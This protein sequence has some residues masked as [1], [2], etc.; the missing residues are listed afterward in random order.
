MQ[1]DAEAH[2]DS[3]RKRTKLDEARG[4][5]EAEQ[6]R[7]QQEAAQHARAEEAT[8]GEPAF[9]RDLAMRVVSR[10]DGVS[11]A[12]RVQQGKHYSQRGADTGAEGFLRRG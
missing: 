7:V 11:L 8:G 5:R 3:R 2:D 9:V 6:E 12:E 10:E 4:E 1:A